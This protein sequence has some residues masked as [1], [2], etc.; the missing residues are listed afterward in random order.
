M[1]VCPVAPT[2]PRTQLSRGE[3]FAAG[4]GA[5]FASKSLTAPIDRIRILFQIDPVKTFSIRGLGETG[6]KIIKREGFF[7]LW[8]GNLAVVMRAMPYAAI[9]FSSFEQYQR[10]LRVVC[11][12]QSQE[13]VVRFWAGAMA[14]ATATTFTYPMDMLRARMALG[15]SSMSDV[16]AGGEVNLTYTSTAREIVRNE[17]IAGLFRGISPTMMGIIPHAGMGFMVFET[18]KPWIQTEFLCLS[19]E[20]ELPL[21]WRLMAGG[22]AGFV[23]QSVSYPLHVVRRRMQVQKHYSGRAHGLVYT[24]VRDALLKILRTEGLVRGLYKGGSL[25]LVK[26]PLTAASGFTANDLL[27]HVLA[28]AHGDPERVPPFLWPDGPDVVRDPSSRLKS[29]D[30]TTFEH[31]VSGGTAGAIAKT[32][33]APADRV[34]I[35]YQTNSRRV[36][37]W[38][39]VARTATTIYNNTGL[40]GLWRGHAATLMQQVPKAAITYMTFDIYRQSM[41]D[42][43]VVDRV[44]ARF[45]AGAMA[46]ATATTCTYP[47]DLMRARM[48]AHWD[49]APCYPNYFNAFESVLKQE[50][51]LALFRGI[52]PTLLGI[53][54]YAGLSFTVYE[55]L[56]ANWVLPLEARSSS[57]W[58]STSARLVSGGL[59]GLVAQTATYPLDIVRRR[60]QVH[61]DA[62]RNEWQA[63]QTIYQTEGLAKGLFKGVSMN[64]VK[65]PI[66]VGVSFTVNDLVKRKLGSMPQ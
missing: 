18:L 54:P 42:A 5:G 34:K 24:S 13:P 32:V 16:S 15:M 19:S 63:F 36:Y 49:M 57:S 39:G 23:S 33:I 20:R 3:L 40:L 17:G 10:L 2:G 52:R 30:L 58:T 31:L 55:S 27:K 50:G 12:F 38:R 65:G 22:V 4:A 7:G 44:S 48:A 47:L 9:Q 8:R 6:L 21:A 41:Y 25:T 59:A 29:K 51:T 66:A 11:P 26:G 14:G 28:R 53:M 61:P 46:G 43:N 62:Y 1:T 60:M 45:I 37:T 56:K 35:L 64:W